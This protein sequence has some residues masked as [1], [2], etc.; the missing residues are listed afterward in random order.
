M[1]EALNSELKS[2]I[3]TLPIEK[4]C[5]EKAEEPPRNVAMSIDTSVS[6]PHSKMF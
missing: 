1:I 6:G 5:T 2:K 4:Y 3:Q